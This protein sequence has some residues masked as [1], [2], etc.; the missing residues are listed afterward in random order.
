MKTQEREGMDNFHGD[1]EIPNDL[2]VEAEMQV[3]QEL[4]RW[5]EE[6]ARTNYVF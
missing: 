6:S 2:N 5:H 3:L 4:A 1:I